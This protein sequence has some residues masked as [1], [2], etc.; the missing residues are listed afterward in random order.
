MKAKNADIV[1]TGSKFNFR[2]CPVTD[3]TFE[4]FFDTL[5][6][7]GASRRQFEDL[8]FCPDVPGIPGEIK[9]KVMTNGDRDFNLFTGMKFS[10]YN[11]LQEC[12]ELEL[13]PDEMTRQ[14]GV[15]HVDMYK[16]AE[17]A[18]KPF[19]DHLKTIICQDGGEQYEYLLNWCAHLIQKPWE[20][21]AVALVLISSTCT[22][23][24][25]GLQL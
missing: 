24:S 15:D 4:R 21:P 20:K 6:G 9:Q 8:V 7:A 10:E 19:L 22:C 1:L 16:C 2:P 23:R 25:I 14:D 12:V 3:I 5:K 11:A 18:C 17:E 13:L